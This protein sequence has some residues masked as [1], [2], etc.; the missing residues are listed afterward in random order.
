[1]KEEAALPAGEGE[2][3]AP[4]KRNRTLVGGDDVQAPIQGLAHVGD[5]RLAAPGVEGG[6]LDEDVGRDPGDEPPYVAGLR[7]TAERLEG[8]SSLDEAPRP[9]EGDAP[10]VDREA[11][12]CG[13]D[14]G[15][16][17]CPRF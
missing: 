6:D 7:A 9:A 15:D 17:W 5:R 13:G 1:V 11:V 8:P 4:G 16:A 14:P 12:P 3:P 10:G 2:E